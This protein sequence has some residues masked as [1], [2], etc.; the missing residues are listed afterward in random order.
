MPEC[1]EDQLIEHDLIEI[2]RQAFKRTCDSLRARDAAD[3][4]TTI[5][6]AKIVELVKAGEVDPERLCS[7]A[8][9]ALARKR[10]AS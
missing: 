6:A 5:V 10:Q 3:A 7:K 4:F 2:M 9:S 8:L 1:E